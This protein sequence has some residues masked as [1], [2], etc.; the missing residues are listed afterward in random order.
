MTSTSCPVLLERL[1]ANAGWAEGLARSLTREDPADITQEAMIIALR[2]P[3]DPGRPL[4]PWLGE[5]VRNVARG[6]FRSRRRHQEHETVASAL[7][8]DQQAGAEEM[9][10]RLQVQR[11]LTELVADLPEPLRQTVLLRYFEGLSSA[12]I[13]RRMGEPAGTVRWRLKQGLD[14]LRAELDA[15]HGGARQKWVRLLVPL[16]T[17]ERATAPPPPSSRLPSQ[18]QPPLPA[19]LGQTRLA[20]LGAAVVAAGVTVAV[21]Q[22]PARRGGGDQGVNS[23]AAITRKA[24]AGGGGLGD[25]ASGAGPPAPTPPPSG[26]ASP[27]VPSF[28]A[29]PAADLP[30]CQKALA[31]RRATISWEEQHQR[32]RE[33][34]AAAPP[35][36]AAREAVAPVVEAILAG[37]DAEPPPHFVECRGSICNIEGLFAS[38]D[39]RRVRLIMIQSDPRLKPLL[40]R[41]PFLPPYNHSERAPRDESGR[42]RDR[43]MIYL[44]MAGPP[45]ALPITIE[46]CQRQRDALD[47]PLPPRPGRPPVDRKNQPGSG[48][49]GG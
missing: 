13:S 32:T 35:N 8:E 6:R 20:L 24:R 5:V 2:H 4:R 21:I 23:Q 14:R 42:P 3:P 28:V 25:L 7:A 22:A 9:L 39:K 31:A 47:R 49:T 29:V 27:G 40:Q 17:S 26:P 36:E 37:P 38:G 10:G 11:L 43:R 45:P 15:R 44:R 1:L 34:F 12:E 18:G 48:G 19:V 46:D 16:E 30:S 33:I 41:E